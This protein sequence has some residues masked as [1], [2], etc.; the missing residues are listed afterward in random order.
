MRM[1]LR[2]AALIDACAFVV[3]AGALALPAREKREPVFQ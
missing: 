3:R 2:A 1:D